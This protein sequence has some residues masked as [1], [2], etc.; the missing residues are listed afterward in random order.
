M[1]ACAPLP[2]FVAAGPLSPRV[3]R[4]RESRISVKSVRLRLNCRLTPLA[5]PPPTAICVMHP[6]IPAAFVHTAELCLW[7]HATYGMLMVMEP[8][9]RG[10][11]KRAGVLPAHNK[12]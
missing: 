10:Q 7:S 9:V 2:L 5:N 6:P 11:L 8:E 4:S 1:R 12:S 3:Q